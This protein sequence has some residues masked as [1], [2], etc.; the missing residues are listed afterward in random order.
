MTFIFVMLSFFFKLRVVWIVVVGELLKHMNKMIFNSGRID[1][2]K[3][4]TLTQLKTWFWVKSKTRGI[5][6]SYY[7]WCLEL[8]VCMSKIIRRSS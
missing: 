7:D 6:F 1:H 8:L 2:N 4:F 3:K 5:R